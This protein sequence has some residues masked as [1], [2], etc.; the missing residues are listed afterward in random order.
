M[1]EEKTQSVKNQAL[2][3]NEY[4]G[5]QKAQD[6]LYQRSTKNLNFS[7]LM[8]LIESEDNTMLAYRNIKANKGS[9]NLKSRIFH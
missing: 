7:N 1:T 2:P 5:I 8:S 3:N 9:L 6:D 4:Y